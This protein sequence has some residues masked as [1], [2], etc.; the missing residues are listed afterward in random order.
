MNNSHDSTFRQSISAEWV[1]SVDPK[2]NPPR[3]AIALVG[4]N[5]T[6]ISAELATQAGGYEKIIA[7][8][9]RGSITCLPVVQDGST[10]VDRMKCLK[11]FNARKEIKAFNEHITKWVGGQP[12]DCF[13][14][15]SQN[16]FSQL[17]SA[18]PL[19]AHYFYIEEGITAIIGGPFGRPKQRKLKQ[20]VSRLQSLIFYGGKVDKYRPFFD[21]THRNYGGAL[22]LSKCAFRGFPKRVILP[23][24]D[25]KSIVEVPADVMIFLD[26]QYII[27]NCDSD[28][29]LAALTAGLSNI[30]SS[31]SIVAIK[32]HPS[33]KNLERRERFKAEILKITEISS[34]I[35]LPSD[36]IAERMAFD[37]N[38]KVLIGTSSLGFYTGE[39]D[40]QTYTFAPRLAASS[41][42]YAQ[43]M[44]EFPPEFLQLCKFA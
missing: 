20:L 33:E 22:A 31:K 44:N 14:H 26:S 36:Y 25:L 32:F 12:Y 27:G 29:Y 40:F 7:I 9:R 10:W 21:T 1:P 24:K 19:C 18:H 6:A 16:A 41:Q 37:P 15:H 35:E 28:Q 23:F 4:S 13:I 43:I 5:T 11:N 39:R 42:K 3:V 30:I 17:L 34:L 38:T 8:T 2:S